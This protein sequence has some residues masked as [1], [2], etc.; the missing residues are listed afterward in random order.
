MKKTTKTPKNKGG[1]TQNRTVDTRIFNPTTSPRNLG[2]KAK[3]RKCGTIAGQGAK[4]TA[5]YAGMAAWINGGGGPT[6]GLNR[7]EVPNRF[8][9]RIERM[10]RARLMRL[11]R[12]GLGIETAQE[13]ISAALELLRRECAEIWGE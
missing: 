7:A 6:F 1:Q 11:A 3:K 12:V 8:K 4:E 5:P 13:H 9:V 10:S 2:E